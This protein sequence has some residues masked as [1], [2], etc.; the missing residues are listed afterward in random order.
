MLLNFYSPIFSSLII[1]L[2]FPLFLHVYSQKFLFLIPLF[3]L[4][5]I[6]LCFILSYPYTYI[7][8]YFSTK[9]FINSSNRSIK[10]ISNITMIVD[11]VITI[12]YT[13]I[14]FRFLLNGVQISF[15]SA[16][17]AYTSR[18]LRSR[19]EYA[20][21]LWRFSPVS[22]ARLFETTEL[23]PVGIAAAFLRSQSGGEALGQEA[24]SRARRREGT[25]RL[26]AVRG[27]S[28]GQSR[29]N[30]TR[31]RVH[32]GGNCSRSRDSCQWRKEI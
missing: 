24:S 22:S 1:F 6:E 17:T 20:S 11:F 15:D 19:E 29:W 5:V 25:V 4:I 12:R 8:I 18:F 3:E 16:R 13:N 21:E 32:R 31:A 30:I 10:K 14:S 28:R 27:E 7:Y 9:I 26:L 23:V 2:L